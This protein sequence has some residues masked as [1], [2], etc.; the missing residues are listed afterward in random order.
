MSIETTILIVLVGE[1]I[2]W[3]GLIWYQHKLGALAREC[4]TRCAIAKPQVEEDQ[5]RDSGDIAQLRRPLLE[6]V[7]WAD[8]AG[9]K[10]EDAVLSR[11]CGD[12]KVAIGPKPSSLKALQ[13]IISRIPDPEKLRDV[14]LWLD[15][16]YEEDDDDYALITDLRRLADEIDLIKDEDAA[17]RAALTEMKHSDKC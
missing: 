12:A 10:H 11:I 15:R 8:S 17:I 6:L 7:V 9:S 4:D 13:S 16:E 1:V 2:L 14:A 3:L 5:L